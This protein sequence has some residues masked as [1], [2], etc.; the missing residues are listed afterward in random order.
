MS[1]ST[2]TISNEEIEQLRQRLYDAYDAYYTRL[3]ENFHVE[4]DKRWQR[5]FSSIDAYLKSVEP[6]RQHWR[7]FLSWDRIGNGTA[8]VPYAKNGT[9]RRNGALHH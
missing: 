5:D 9:S 8:S 6:N 7:E 3:V 1:D 2:L 4:R